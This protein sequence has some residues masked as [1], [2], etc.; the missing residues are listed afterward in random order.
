[1]VVFA[2]HLHESTM[3]AHV[4]PIL[5]PLAPPSLSPPSGLS[6]CTGFECPVS[7]LELGP[8]IYFTSGNI[9]VSVLFSQIIPP[10]P[11]PTESKSVLYICLFGCLAYRVIITTFLNSILYVLIYCIGVFLSDLLHSVLLMGKYS[12]DLIVFSF[13]FDY[14]K[15]KM[16]INGNLGWRGTPWRLNRTHL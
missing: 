15:N 8:V 5:N 6:Q 13:L 4:S 7:C 3:G 11:S 12:Y 16:M 10:L 9:Y 2:I 14:K 1:M